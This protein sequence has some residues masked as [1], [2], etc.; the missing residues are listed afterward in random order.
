[1]NYYDPYFALLQ[2]FF[3]G[4]DA[5]GTTRQAKPRIEKSNAEKL[6]NE[7]PKEAATMEKRAASLRKQAG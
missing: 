6:K 7:K 4:Q 3:H 5:A 1:M 2:M